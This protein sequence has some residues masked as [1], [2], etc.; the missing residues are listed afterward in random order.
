M[1][2]LRSL[3]LVIVLGILLYWLHAFLLIGVDQKT[4]AFYKELKQELKKKDYA[5]SLFVLS[6]RRYSWDNGFLNEYGNAAKNSKHLNGEAIDIIV[7]DVN[8]DG[9]SNE[10]DVDIVFDILNEKI[11][12]NEGGIGTYKK[13]NG[14]FSRQMVHFDCRGHWARWHK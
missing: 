6:G 1:E 7:L 12:K 9:E 10:K 2:L 3:F 5:T 11:V 13:E 8:K 14:F 4:K